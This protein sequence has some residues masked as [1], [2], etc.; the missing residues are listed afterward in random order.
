[1]RECERQGCEKVLPIDR[2]KLLGSVAMVG[3]H[4]TLARP[5]ERS[6]NEKARM[7]RRG[8]A[9][10]NQT[11]RLSKPEG[12]FTGRAAEG[13]ARRRLRQPR[14]RRA[15]A[16]R[17]GLNSGPTH[18]GAKHSSDPVVARDVSPAGRDRP[19][20]FGRRE[21]GCRPHAPRQRW[22]RSTGPPFIRACGYAALAKTGPSRQDPEAGAIRMCT[23]MRIVFQG[24]LRNANPGNGPHI[25][26]FRNA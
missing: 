16:T 25:T 9:Q 11:G 20:R 17:G 8:Q 19:R 15:R 2:E 3:H 4:P 1:M 5:R 22:A 12:R 6:K 23:A 24:D 18:N 26:A 10:S 14:D 13:H 7:P 21:P